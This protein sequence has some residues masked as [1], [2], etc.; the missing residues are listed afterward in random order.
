MPSSHDTDRALDHTVI[1]DTE[2]DFALRIAIVCDSCGT[3]LPIGNIRQEVE[4]ATVL[5]VPPCETCTQASHYKGYM[6]GQDE[7]RGF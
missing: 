5:E 6:E 2:E 4:Q 3:E 7:H 1:L